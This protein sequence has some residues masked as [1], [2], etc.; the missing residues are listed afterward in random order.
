MTASGVGR[1]YYELTLYMDLFNNE[2]VAYALS[3]LRGDRNTYFD[4][5]KDFIKKE[6]Y[7]NF[8]LTLHSDQTSYIPQRP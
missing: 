6:E 7:G 8:K 3:N 5:L 4:G 2:I 1:E